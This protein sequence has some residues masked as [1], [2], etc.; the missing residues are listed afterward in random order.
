MVFAN[1]TLYVAGLFNNIGTP[2]TAR[3]GFA[4][5][6]TDGAVKPLNPTVEPPGS[7]A[8]IAA[9]ADTVYISGTFT[10]VNSTPRGGAAALTANDGTLTSWDPNPDDTLTSMAINSTSVI[11]GGQ[12]R[13][14]RGVERKHLLAFDANA[15]L[16]NWK[17]EADNEVAAIAVS[18]TTVYVGGTFNTLGGQPRGNLGA[19]S[20]TDGTLSDWNPNVDGEVLALAV[21]ND[22]V[23]AGGTFS[24]ANVGAPSAASRTNLAAFTL[25]SA[26]PNPGT[27]T[28]WMPNANLTV[29][30][31]ALNGTNVYAGGDFT[32]L[33]GATRNHL[34][35]VGVASNTATSWDPNITGDSVYAIVATDD[36][37]YAG[38]EFTGVGSG[39]TVRDNFVALDTN[40]A[41][42]AFAP[43]P[44]QPV[45]ALLLANDLLHIA[46]DFSAVDAGVMRGKYAAYGALD[47]TP[48]LENGNDFLR[49]FDLTVRTL[50]AG[51]AGRIFAGGDFTTANGVYHSGFA[52][53][54]PGQ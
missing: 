21:S 11:L 45:Y 32:M 33:G 31:L 24:N 6:G 37:V 23:Y 26:T 53:L 18:G 51:T 50:S 10:A 40:A 25:A 14:L 15:N 42:T 3:A 43:N 17:P 28:S 22:A 8:T 47:S 49:N 35:S 36:V 7:V 5:I 16:T 13:G 9:T 4:A 52:A 27:V 48:A 29:R 44:D 2:S 38:G 12:H 41:A 20:T 54:I 34:G 46:G 19:V 30:A 39:P 1:S